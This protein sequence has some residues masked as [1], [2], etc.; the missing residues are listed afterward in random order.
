MNP[1]NCFSS[2]PAHCVTDNRRGMVRASGKLA[3]IDYVEVDS[4]GTALVVHF[5]GAVPDSLSARNVIIEGGRR[6]RDI[7][8]LS[9]KLNNKGNDACLHV[10]LDKPGDFSTYCLCLIEPGETS[11]KCLEDKPDET[12]RKIPDGIDP[13]YSC[14]PLSFRTECPT[15]LDCK[16]QPCP[17]E[18][19]LPPLSINYLARDFQ[20][21]RQ[22][23]LD[24][25]LVTMPQWRERHIPD[26]G[27][28][29]VEL[30]AYVADQLSY[31]LDAVATEAYLSTARLRISVR[32]HARL[33]D[34][35]M[36]EGCNARAWVCLEAEGDQTFAV[37]DLA[38]A[39]ISDGAGSLSPGIVDWEILE[40]IPGALIFEPMDLEGTGRI[41]VIAANN[42]IHF[43]TWGGLDCCLPAGSTRASLLANPGASMT[44]ADEDYSGR[45]EAENS[46]GRYA[47]GQHNTS[48]ACGAE[49][50]EDQNSSSMKSSEPEVQLKIGDILIFEEIRGVRT[51]EAADADPDKRHVVRLTRADYT[52][53][54]LYD[55][56]IIEIEWGREDALPFV[57]CLSTRTD[58]PDCRFVESAVARGN[59][60]LV[61]H[62]LTVEDNKYWKVE[63]DF[64][65]DCCNCEGAAI[66]V[67]EIAKPF[68][69]ILENTLLTHADPIDPQKTGS[70]SATALLR[71]D[72]RKAA[73][74][75]KLDD[76]QS[77]G[78]KA[79]QSYK[80]SETS[81]T[82]SDIRWRNEWDWSVVPDLL[83]SSFNDRHFV[84]EMSDEGLAHLRFG[85]GDCGRRPDPGTHFRAR[86][87]IGNGP[88]GNVGR[89][90]ILWL[91]RKSGIISGPQIRSRNPLEAVGGAE[92]EPVTQVKLY[93]P[94]AYSRVL[95]RAVAA[96]DYAELAERDSRVQSSHA[97]LAWTGSWYEADVALDPFEKAERDERLGKDIEAQ[98]ERMRRIGHDLRI[99]PARMVPLVISL[100]VC[101]APHYSRSDV[102]MAIRELLS[103]RRMKDG[104]LGFFHPDQFEFDTDIKASRL[105]AA[106]QELEGV[107]QVEL[108]EF[109]RADTLNDFPSVTDNSLMN[110]FISI[111]RNEIA[112]LDTDGNLPESRS[113]RIKMT[114]GL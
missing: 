19:A 7:R 94:Q 15:T 28:I 38:F 106:V 110:N 43:Y 88:M 8:V 87:R 16:P 37:S 72:P 65:A 83:N 93:A 78:F 29:L 17:P 90:S 102:E 13:R 22:L 107:L 82:G 64:R 89:D 52:V 58:A 91:A 68:S 57:L 73:A 67:S 10:I 26:I 45:T 69:V 74:S 111:R 77:S 114:G 63:S 99:V 33:L 42:E 70:L 27:I 62:G 34:Y 49:S 1:I 86:Y 5:F 113:L 32:R 61:D 9:V 100:E 54:P 25:L 53:D 97:E 112:Q 21:F 50:E 6:I 109:R 14:A 35:R 12:Q 60:I 84:V 47:D 76:D 92:S 3:G 59:V 98:L 39:V 95:E 18:S 40:K 71:Q 104:R 30:M 81:E 85:D 24:R 101:V 51:G 103:N 41:E 80:D 105:I 36:H 23:L 79:E 31:S 4:K 46:T 56:H 55:T 96:R 20:S 44:A 108:K 48:S 11:V 75:I 66:D 2:Q